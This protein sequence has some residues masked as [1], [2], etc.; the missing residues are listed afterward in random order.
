[1][2]INLYPWALDK[3]RQL[4]GLTQKQKGLTLTGKIYFTFLTQRL[5]LSVVNFVVSSLKAEERSKCVKWLCHNIF[6]MSFLLPL[7]STKVPEK[8]AHALLA[9]NQSIS[10]TMPASK[11][12]VI[13]V[14]TD[15]VKIFLRTT[16]INTPIHTFLSFLTLR[17][18]F[19][20]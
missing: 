2:L 4:D 16:I 20:S 15:I 3:G 18:F 14:R 9:T 12:R 13:N 8:C 6:Y 1:M 7:A 17:G 10:L 5:G 11:V 19:T